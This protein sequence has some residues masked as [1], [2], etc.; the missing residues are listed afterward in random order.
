MNPTRFSRRSPANR[1][2]SRPRSSWAPASGQMSTSA[3]VAGAGFPTSAGT[4]KC[5][6]RSASSR[7]ATARPARNANA[8]KRARFIKHCPALASRCP[9]LGKAR[10]MPAPSPRLSRLIPRCHCAG[11][12]VRYSLDA[13]QAGGGVLA[14]GPRRARPGR[15]RA[16][17]I[18]VAVVGDAVA[19]SRR[20]SGSLRRSPSG[21]VP[22][23][24]RPRRPGHQRRR[25]AHLPR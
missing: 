21:R 5:S 23:A 7:A 14:S 1:G 3:R 20:L 22:P 24:R 2:R 16:R 15:R 13:S 12:T 11:E 9:V 18:C 25:P 4:A 19:A 8:R 10:N 17:L 6:I